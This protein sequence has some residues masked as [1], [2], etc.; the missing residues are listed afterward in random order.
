MRDQVYRR[1]LA[2]ELKG[3][4]EGEAGSRKVPVSAVLEAAVRD[5]LKNLRADIQGDEEQ[6]RLQASAAKCRGVVAGRKR[7]RAGIA[8]QAI[9]ARL[10]GLDHADFESCRISFKGKRR[11]RVVPQIGAVRRAGLRSRPE[12]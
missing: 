5:G 12:R 4:L 3:D 10:G 6:G 9:R 1:R 8:R 7:R 2:S 11:F